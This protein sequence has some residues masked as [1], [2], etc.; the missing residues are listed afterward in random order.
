MTTAC[1]QPTARSS[2]QLEPAG[3][4]AAEE[5]ANTLTAALGALL[6]LGGLVVLVALAA[7][8]GDPWRIVAFSIYGVSLVV[9]HGASTAY[10]G[11]RLPAR[12]SR[13]RIVDHAAIFILIAGTYTPIFLVTLRGTWGWSLFGLLWGLA[14]LGVFKTL[15]F[16]GRLK[17]LTIGVYLLMGWLGMIAFKPLFAALSFGGFAWLV[18]GGVLYSGGV[19]FYVR[20]S[21]RHHHA[22]WHVFV[23]AGGVCHF[24][25]VIGYILPGR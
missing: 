5:R 7:A 2:N 20:K 21:L 23:I 19:L 12:K 4:S 1:E 24:I 8:T 16:P 10:H 9:L 17:A 11:A 22:I 25:A 14:L 18:G 15:L 6:A 13:L 3:Y